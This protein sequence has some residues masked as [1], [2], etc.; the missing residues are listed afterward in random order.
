ML[1]VLRGPKET[2]ETAALLD[3]VG[4]Q[5]LL[6][7]MESQARGGVQEW[8]G[9]VELQVKQAPRVTGALTVCQVSQETR[10]TEETEESL[11]LMGLLESQERR[12]LMD[13]LGREGSQGNQVLEVLL[14]QGGHLAHLAN[15]EFVELMEYKGQKATWVHLEK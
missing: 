2:T 12:V 1:Q 11:V 8:T 14:G 6:E 3:H 7:L 5:V 15:R 4:C 9:V 10:D 13:L